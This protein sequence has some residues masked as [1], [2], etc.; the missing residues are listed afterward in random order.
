MAAGPTD[1]LKAIGQQTGSI[2][3]LRVKTE[4]GVFKKDLK[5]VLF[6]VPLQYFPETVDDSKR[7][8]YATMD[9]LGLSHPLYQWIN[10]GERVVSFTAMFTHEDATL[11]STGI[12]PTLKKD[13]GATTPYSVDVEGA[14]SFLY[15]LTYP[16][17]D[18]GT[19]LPYPPPVLYLNLPGIVGSGIIKSLGVTGLSSSGITCILADIRI[20]YQDWFPDGRIRIAT[21]DLT[22]YEII[23]LDLIYP[24][25]YDNFIDSSNGYFSKVKSVY[26][27]SKNKT[28]GGL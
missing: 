13:A 11:Y 16:S 20:N 5:E 18:E 15:S 23:Q 28:V 7:A 6:S 1:L 24:I 2:E 9:P 27:V 19:K 12:Q 22:F 25:G 3:P 17:Y 26:N 4:I 14:L 8:N 10:G 21:A